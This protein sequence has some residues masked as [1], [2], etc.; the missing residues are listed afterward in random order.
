MVAGCLEREQV[1]RFFTRELRPRKRRVSK[2]VTIEI[3]PHLDWY[4]WRV[5]TAERLHVSLTDLKTTWTLLDL[6]D[7][8]DA[9]DLLD[10]LEDKAQLAAQKDKD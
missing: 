3:P 7:A 9:L 2:T 1:P 8:H 5:L 6:A 4:I 10:Q